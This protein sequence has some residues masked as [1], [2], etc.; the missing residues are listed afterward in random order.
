MGAFRRFARLPPAE[1]RLVVAAVLVLASVRLGLTLLPFTA[2]DRLL[3]WLGRPRPGRAVTS[4][5]IAWAVGVTAAH[6]PRAT[7]LSRALAARVLL[8]RRGI[9]AIVRIG[10]AREGH[11]GLAS[12]AWVEHEGRVLLGDGH[13]DR[14]TP[15]IT[16]GSE[17]P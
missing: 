14:Y 5:R 10:V 11:A 7:C 15:F 8:G 16:W 2:L 3:R 13:L 12:H 4:E 1:R 9:P 6:V 17:R